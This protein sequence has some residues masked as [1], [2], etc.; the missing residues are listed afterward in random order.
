MLIHLYVSEDQVKINILHFCF[1]SRQSFGDMFALRVFCEI[2]HWHP[3]HSVLIAWITLN[4]NRYLQ[5]LVTL[6]LKIHVKWLHLQN[7][8]FLLSPF[9]SNTLKLL[10]LTT[11][12]EHCLVLCCSFLSYSL[13]TWSAWLSTPLWACHVLSST[14]KHKHSLK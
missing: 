2:L 6:L 11:M 14:W 10:S 1:F 5:L 12:W 8:G 13:D 9:R 7:L 4:Y 3:H